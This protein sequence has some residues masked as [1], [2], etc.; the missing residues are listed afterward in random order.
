MT[1]DDYY[2]LIRRLAQLLFEKKG[3]QII[4]LDL[5]GISSTT[6]YLLI[7]N[8]NVERHVLA[9]AIE[10]EKM[11]RRTAKMKLYHEEGKGNGDWVVL[12]YFDLMIHLFIPSMRQK[13]QLD[14]LWP[15][16]RVIDLD[17]NLNPASPQ[18][19]YS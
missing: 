5:Q 8:G 7:A 11:T 1:R 6:D 15:E 12:D 16:A 13:Y 4:A 2:T 18:V 19:F 10:I 9:L 14:R 17:L 3:S